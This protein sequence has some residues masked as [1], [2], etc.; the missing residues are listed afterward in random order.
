MG[1]RHPV[2]TTIVGCY[3]L[4]IIP[5][6]YE[7]HTHMNEA[8]CTYQRVMLHTQKRQPAR[9]YVCVSVHVSV[10][11]CVRACAREFVLL[12]I[13]EFGS[14]TKSE[15]STERNRESEIGKD[16]GRAREREGVRG[17][18]RRARVRTQSKGV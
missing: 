3:V 2:L 15:K 6:M 18:G 13:V 12:L 5:H 7:R 14:E 1:I 8:C 10:R 11:V 4:P 17:K 16:K 9:L